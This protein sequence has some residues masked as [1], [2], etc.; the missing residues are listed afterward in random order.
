MCNGGRHA[1]ASIFA[2]SLGHTK[3][4]SS[5]L[6]S[7]QIDCRHWTHGT[8]LRETEML[9]SPCPEIFQFTS[10]HIL[11]FDCFFFW[12][13]CGSGSLHKDFGRSSQVN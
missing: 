2:K 7:K 8:C 10:S 12:L 4:L 11:E 9:V 1:I 13:D 3:I 6:N 5:L